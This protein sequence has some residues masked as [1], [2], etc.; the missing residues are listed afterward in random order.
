MN[1]FSWCGDQAPLTDQIKITH[2]GSITLGRFGGSSASGAWKNEDACWIRADEAQQLVVILDA[3]TSPDSARAVI[4]GL[5][6]LPT[7]WT[8][9]PV[10]EAF[11]SFQADIL[12]MLS[13]LETE[14]MLGETALLAVYQ[15]EGFLHWFSIGDNTVYAFHE[16]FKSLGQTALNQRLFYQWVGHANSLKLKVPC[17]VSGTIELRQGQSDIVMLTDGVLEIED[18]PFS[19]SN[20]LYQTLMSQGIA[21]VLKV[22]EQKHGRDNATMIHWQ[23]YKSQQGLRPT[24][25]VI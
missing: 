3:H 2:H 21:G 24:R 18:M 6:S 1:H 25:E 9:L 19:D 14:Q 17:Y 10:A 12:S 5:D 11:T 16:D 20:T 4:D 13:G 8:A 7:R 22:V 23:V 15:R